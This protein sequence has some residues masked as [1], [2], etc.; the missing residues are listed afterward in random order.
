MSL[1]ASTG[2][3]AGEITRAAPPVSVVGLGL[4]G[5]TLNE[6]VLIAT[7][8]YTLMQMVWFI[9]SKFIRKVKDVSE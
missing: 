3:V 7:L 4:A 5:F 9:Y 1:V 6:W 2:E 8:A